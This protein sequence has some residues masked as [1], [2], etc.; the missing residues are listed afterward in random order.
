MDNLNPLGWT[1]GIRPPRQTI[2]LTRLL[3]LIRIAGKGGAFGASMRW[4]SA[5]ADADGGTVMVDEGGAVA[6][7]AVCLRAQ[8]ALASKLVD[9]VCDI[10]RFRAAAG[11]LACHAVLARKHDGVGECEGYFGAS[12]SSSRE[13][14]LFVDG[15][16]GVD[17]KVEYR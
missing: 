14:I 1:D 5:A 10:A 9:H 17:T 16:R 7:L 3:D 6:G 8:A 2:T 4:V 15:S 11:G 12:V 13:I